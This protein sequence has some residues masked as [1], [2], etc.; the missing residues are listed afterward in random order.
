MNRFST[1]FKFVLKL[2]VKNTTTAEM[3]VLKGMSKYY[4]CLTAATSCIEAEV[5]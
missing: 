4:L 2:L 3:L 5:V 1:T